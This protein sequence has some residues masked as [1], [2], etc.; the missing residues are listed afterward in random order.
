MKIHQLFTDTPPTELIIRV[1]G[2]FGLDSLEDTASFSQASMSRL[3]TSDVIKGLQ[4]EL[5][6]YYI[7]CKAKIY[8]PVEIDDRRCITILRQ[9]LRLRSMTLYSQQVYVQKKKTTH[10]MINSRRVHDAHM[11]R[12]DKKSTTIHFL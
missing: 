10:Y 3:A 5:E 6:K 12:I 2:A 8:L 7:P 4:P 1:I 9:L 11:M